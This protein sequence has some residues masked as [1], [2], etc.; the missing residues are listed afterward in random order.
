MGE[1]EKSNKKVENGQILVKIKMGKKFY[2][3]VNI[4]L[5]KTIKML[6]KTNTYYQ[7]QEAYFLLFDKVVKS[8]E[9]NPFDA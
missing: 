7:K 1:I 8:F 2:K 3:N 5:D 6:N 9:I 4:K